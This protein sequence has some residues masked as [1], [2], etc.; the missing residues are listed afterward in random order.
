MFRDSD[1][2]IPDDFDIEACEE[3][4]TPL[5]KEFLAKMEGEP[6]YVGFNVLAY[7]Y[8]QLCLASLDPTDMPNMDYLFRVMVSRNIQHQIDYEN[9]LAKRN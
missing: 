5:C 3:R 1:G 6:V 2:L 7:L 4:I 8:A 9:E